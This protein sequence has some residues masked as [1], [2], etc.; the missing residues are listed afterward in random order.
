MPPRRDDRFYVEADANGDEAIWRVVDGERDL[1]VLFH[2]EV[3]DPDLWDL[4]CRVVS[5]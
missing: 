5:E 2:F 4:I 3:R 1:A